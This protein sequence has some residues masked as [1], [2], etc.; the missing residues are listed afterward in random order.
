MYENDVKNKLNIIGT[1]Y[2]KT[3][4][5]GGEIVSFLPDVPIKAYLDDLLFILTI[6][7]EDNFAP[8][9]CR[10]QDKSREENLPKEEVDFEEVRSVGFLVEK[11]NQIL[12]C[13]PKEHALVDLDKIV[14]IGTVPYNN[15][16]TAP[17]YIKKKLY[18]KNK[19]ELKTNKVDLTWDYGQEPESDYEPG[20]E[21]G[22]TEFT[23]DFVESIKFP[24]PRQYHGFNGRFA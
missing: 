8:A 21:P 24:E 19:S 3:S 16:K 11:R 12:V 22:I 5:S 17:F 4:K 15:K 18:D 10:L 1:C 9:Y 14:V 6:P 7:N 23:P 20:S 13:A 2:L